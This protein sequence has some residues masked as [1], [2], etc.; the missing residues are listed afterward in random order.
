VTG[1]QTCA[2]P[3]YSL[4]NE[5]FKVI[6]DVYNT[7]VE[8]ETEEPAYSSYPFPEARKG[9]NKWITYILNAKNICYL[10]LPTGAGKTAIY[11]T[12]AVESG[13][14]TLVI[15][16][17]NGLQEQ[18]ASYSVRMGVPI[19]Y[20]FERTK[21]C[22]KCNKDS[23]NPPC[24]KK[25]IRGGKWYFKLNGKIVEYP[26]SDCPYEIKKNIIKDLFKEGRCIAVMNQGNFWFLR[27]QAEFVVIDEADETLRSITDAVSYPE[28][29]DSR[30]PHEVLAWMKEKISKMVEKVI[31]ALE[32][33][34]RDDELV[35]LNMLLNKLE[36][37]LK[38]IE[39][40]MSYPSDK[41]ITYIRGK[42]TYVEVFDEPVN[43][44]K[45]IFPEAKVCLVTAT[46]PLNVEVSNDK[47][48]MPFRARVIYA[49]IG[50]M[51]VKNVFGKNNID[52]LEKAAE[53]IVKTY[54]Y[55]VKLTG[56]K[57]API[58]CGNLARHGV[59]IYEILKENGFKVLLM[60]EGKQMQTIR[61][62]LQGDYDFLCVVAAEYG[63]DWSFSPIQYILKVPY[64]DKEDPRLKAIK[65]LLGDQKFNEWYD[66][67]ALSRLIQACGR[68]A[69]D[70]NDFGITI[71]LDSCFERLYN[72]F[73]DKIPQ[74]FKDRLVWLDNKTIGKED[75]K[76]NSS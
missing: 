46:P 21:M 13:L 27:S 68:N 29:Y 66:W 36:N 57:K 73:K 50:N 41:L 69:R 18:V 76:D 42:S 4:L 20:L 38:K 64:A 10:T 17:R 44:V 16:P 28:W 65:R 70:P 49:P 75:S 34:R 23:Q 9:H 35:R 31:K 3:I 25:F 19:L 7:K 24:L 55:I 62:F 74:W 71:I 22:N 63:Y 15:V 54:D 33:V 14:K 60:E 45:R 37:K 2:L 56:M 58:H 59:R 48:I 43:V 47:D 1:V 51:S 72:R 67:D 52:L 8:V 32:D 39:F 30:D 12:A 61:E 11:L 53:F 26:C 40:F 6:G 5:V